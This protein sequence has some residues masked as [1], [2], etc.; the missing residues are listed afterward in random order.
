MAQRRRKA[1]RSSPG[2]SESRKRS[3]AARGRKRSDR[4]AAQLDR[5]NRSGAA[6]DEAPRRDD[7]GREWSRADVEREVRVI[8]AQLSRLETDTVRTTTRFEDDLSWDNWFVLSVVK[9][10][11]ARL[12]ETLS[13]FV[14][15]QLETVGDLVDYVWSRMEVVT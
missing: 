1:R 4:R 14:V 8:V 13:D 7:A 15:L 9:P 11:R 10:I 5:P 3:T 12:H 2:R 6:G